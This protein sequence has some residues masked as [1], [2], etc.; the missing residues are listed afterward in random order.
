MKT[1]HKKFTVTENR[2]P[3]IIKYQESVKLSGRKTVATPTIQKP[4]K[5]QFKSAV[6][7]Q[8]VIST[9][10]DNTQTVS[11]KSTARSLLKFAGTW[12][13]DD[14]EECLKQVYQ[15]RGKITF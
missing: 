1:I 13:G 2:Q 8:S 7:N 15:L 14:L 10:L 6:D 3:E 11:S 12:A 5:N 4:E 9:T